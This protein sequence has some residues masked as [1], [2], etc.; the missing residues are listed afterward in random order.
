MNV[1]V[2][3]DWGVSPQQQPTAAT[4]ASDQGGGPLGFAGTVHKETVADAVGLTT[5]PGDEFGGGPTMPM[6]P[7]TWQNK[8]P[9]QGYEGGEHS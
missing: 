2:D 6:L 5:L 7:G 4:A 1:D 8:E 9:A 3:P